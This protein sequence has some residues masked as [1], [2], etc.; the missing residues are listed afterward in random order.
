[1]DVIALVYIEPTI[2]T[3]SCILLLVCNDV[4]PSAD[5][6]VLAL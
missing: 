6:R 4:V 3:T 5:I 2:G 1:M